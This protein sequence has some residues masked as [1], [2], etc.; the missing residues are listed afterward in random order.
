MHSRPRLLLALALGMASA[1]TCYA[2]QNSSIDEAL[3]SLFAVHTFKQ[4]AIAPV[5]KKIARA[6]SSRGEKQSALFVAHPAVGTR[7][8]PT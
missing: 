5:G 4:V 3:D 8:L 2:L 6:E 7:G 1:A